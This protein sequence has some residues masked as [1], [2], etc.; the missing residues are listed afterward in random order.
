VL[1]PAAGVRALALV[2]EFTTLTIEP[3]HTLTFKDNFIVR[4]TKA[5]TNRLLVRVIIF[6]AV[7]VWCA[8]FAYNSLIPSSA[9][10]ILSSLFLKKIYGAVCHQRIAKT[11]FINGHYFFVCAR[12]TGI[13]SGALILSFISLFSL[14]NLSGKTKFL[15]I[16]AIPMLIDVVSTTTGIYAYSKIIALITGLF[17]GSAVFV[18]ILAALENNFMDKSL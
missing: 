5:L 17:F 10:T 18:Y 2:V 15:V 3:M 12:C 16:S 6:I 9:Y 1:R 14:H 4:I 7:A 13:Y 8:G 11:F